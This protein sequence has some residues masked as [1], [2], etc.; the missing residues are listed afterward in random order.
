M[1]YNARNILLGHF[2]WFKLAKRD[3]GI[4]ERSVEKDMSATIRDIV[5]KLGQNAGN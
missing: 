1:M 3:V 5:S 2:V 4:A